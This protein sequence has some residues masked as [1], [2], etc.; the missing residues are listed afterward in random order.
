MPGGATWFNQS[1]GYADAGRFIYKIAKQKNDNG[2]HFPLFGTCLG[3]E[4]FLFLAAGD[5]NC[6]V[7]CNS[8]RQ[9]LP[10]YFTPGICNLE[11]REPRPFSNALV[12]DFKESRLFRDAPKTIIKIL[13]KDGVTANF[14]RFCMTEKVRNYEPTSD[15]V[16]AMIQCDDLISEFQQVRLGQRMEVHVVRLRCKRTAISVNH[17]TQKVRLPKANAAKGHSQTNLF[18]DT[19]STAPSSTRRRI[20]TNGSGTETYRTRKVQSKCPSILLTSW[21]T[22]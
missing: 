22:K 4:L 17:R 1:G 8:Q 3:F 11:S 21:A 2:Q 6:L 16:P 9:S 15:D 5:R 18:A 13:E 20:C 7:D 10:L 19:P 12:S 14:H